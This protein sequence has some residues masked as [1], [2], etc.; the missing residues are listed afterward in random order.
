MK[1]QAFA[2][3]ENLAK[4]KKESE[5]KTNE[6]FVSKPLG[7]SDSWFRVSP[8]F[9]NLFSTHLVDGTHMAKIFN[10]GERCHCTGGC[11]VSCRDKSIL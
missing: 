6:K 8:R 11:C 10:F 4:L 3:K 5:E 7:F 2:R 9:F 1:N